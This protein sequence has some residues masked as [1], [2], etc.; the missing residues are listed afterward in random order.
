MSML[1]NLLVELFTLVGFVAMYA[2]LLA[3]PT[4]LLWDYVMPIIFALP[5]IT[6]F[7][8]LGLNLLCGILFRSRSSS[9]N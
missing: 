2:V 5:K 6:L 4:M 8:A 7:Q 9:S 3:L 1:W